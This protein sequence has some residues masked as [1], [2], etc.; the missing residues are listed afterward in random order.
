MS[1]NES[2]I[3]II[4]NDSLLQNYISVVKDIQSKYDK[5]IKAEDYNKAAYQVYK[6]LFSEI[7]SN[8]ET[9]IYS[10]SPFFQV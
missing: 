3:R 2:G 10:D 5:S 4:Q 1:V 6:I 9:V 7:I 8:Y